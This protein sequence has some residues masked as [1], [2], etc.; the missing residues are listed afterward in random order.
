MIKPLGNRIFLE[1]DEQ[2][3]RKGS[4]ILLKKEGQYAPLMQELLLV[5]VLV[6][7]IKNIK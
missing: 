4:I 3:D 5:L 1:K 6:W 7:K 2:P